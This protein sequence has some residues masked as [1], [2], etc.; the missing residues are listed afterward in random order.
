MFLAGISVLDERFSGGP[1]VPRSESS[2]HSCPFE[3]F[4]NYPSIPYQFGTDVQDRLAV[5]GLYP[6][7]GSAT[8]DMPSGCQVD[9]VLPIRTGQCGLEVPV[10]F[11][12]RRR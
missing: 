1:S 9:D 4:R 8:E 2:Q 7:R 6:P 10:L 12:G 11:L 3:V 5:D